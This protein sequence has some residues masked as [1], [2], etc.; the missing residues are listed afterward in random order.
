MN[1]NRNPAQSAAGL[2]LRIGVDD[3]HNVAMDSGVVTS[4]LLDPS[5]VYA[6]VDPLTGLQVGRTGM[7]FLTNPDE[8]QPF[9]IYL[10]FPRG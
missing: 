1:L 2:L 5:G 3:W 6:V 4:R 7:T 9:R 8:V 10:L